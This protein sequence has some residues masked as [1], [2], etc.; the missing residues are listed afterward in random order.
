MNGEA[1]LAQLGT[2]VYSLS[3]QAATNLSLNVRYVLYS[4]INRANKICPAWILI[5]NL[6]FPLSLND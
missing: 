1:D 2:D 4:L 3:G 5:R 6:G